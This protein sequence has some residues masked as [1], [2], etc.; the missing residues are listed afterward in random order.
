MIVVALIIYFLPTFI[1]LF[2]K[3][4]NIGQ[5]VIVNLFLGWTFFGWIVALIMAFGDKKDHE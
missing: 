4:K 2:R 5:T 3:K 1:A